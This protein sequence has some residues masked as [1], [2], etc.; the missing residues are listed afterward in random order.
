VQI[1]IPDAAY[2]AVADVSGS[3]RPD[4]LIASDAS[5]IALL[6][7]PPARAFSSPLTLYQSPTGALVRSLA[8]AD[9]NGDG[10]PDILVA[11]DAGVRVLFLARAGGTVAVARVQ[12]LYVNAVPGRFSAVAVADIDGDGQADVVICDQGGATVTILLNSPD[13]G[14]QFRS[15]AHYPLPTGA[16]LSVVVAD[17]NGDAHADLVVG[18]PSVVA[19][20]LQDAAHVGTFLGAEAYDA[21]I[22]AGSVAVGDI[23]GD[24]RPDIVT[25]SGVSATQ[26]SGI[27][28]VPPGVLFQDP[29][30]PGSFLGIRNLE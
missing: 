13:G 28:R 3:G 18:G 4:L 16:G 25:N 5:V 20:L 12:E 22:G 11:D 30:R 19:V 17:L 23:D 14:G 6:S 15:P 27:L 26:D 29:S 10:V 24:G 9:L 21:P 7:G 1:L 8:V 2:A